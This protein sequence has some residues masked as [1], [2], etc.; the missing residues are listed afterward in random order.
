MLQFHIDSP[1]DSN[2]RRSKI[3]HDT[4]QIIKNVY[5]VRGNKTK[6]S[7]NHRSVALLKAKMQCRIYPEPRVKA[8]TT[9][10]EVYRLGKTFIYTYALRAHPIKVCYLCFYVLKLFKQHSLQSK[11]IQYQTA[12]REFDR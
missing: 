12:V 5:L 9:H 1:P 3:Q 8:H 10:G 11:S 2:I 4:K 6:T 7:S